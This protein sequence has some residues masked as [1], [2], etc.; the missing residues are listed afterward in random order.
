[1]HTKFDVSRCEIQI[2]NQYH[3]WCILNML[4]ARQIRIMFRISIKLYMVVDLYGTLMHDFFETG[5]AINFR[6]IGE[7][8]EKRPISQ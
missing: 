8:V 2:R 4:F 1:M 3:I 7:N 5:A 6:E